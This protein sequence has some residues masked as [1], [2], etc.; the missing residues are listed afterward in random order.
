LTWG[1]ESATPWTSYLGIH[2]NGAVEIE[3]GPAG[4][5]TRQDRDGNPVRLFMLGSIVRWTWTGLDLHRQIAALAELRKGPVEVTVALR[6]LVGASLADLGEGWQEPHNA[7]AD[8]VPT[9]VEG[10]ALLR[11]EVDD[12]SD[13]DELKAA[14]LEIGSRVDNCFGSHQDRHLDHRGDRAGEFVPDRR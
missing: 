12:I 11:I 10:H 8:R 1:G 7:W 3:M 14:A 4:G 13:T 6:D 2:H 5:W 9:A